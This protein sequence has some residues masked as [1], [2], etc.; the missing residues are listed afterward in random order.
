M[1]WIYG[2]ACKLYC[3]WRLSSA[4]SKESRTWKSSCEIIDVSV[5]LSV[6]R[7][8]RLNAMKPL[9]HA[10]LTYVRIAIE[11]WTSF[12]AIATVLSKGW[13]SIYVVTCRGICASI[14]VNGRVTTDLLTLNKS[15]VCWT[16]L[17]CFR[18]MLMVF[19]SSPHTLRCTWKIHEIRNVR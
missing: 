16:A 18:R 1:N 19:E 12:C 7:Y 2:D 4:T 3:S 14:I 17:I 9:G 13:S 11:I 6:S 8:I 5:S 15:K 10:H